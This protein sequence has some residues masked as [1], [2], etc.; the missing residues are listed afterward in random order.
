VCLFSPFEATAASPF[1]T[2]DGQRFIDAEGRHL[3]LHG[4]N[5]VS[6]NRRANYQP[7]VTAE[8][9][10]MLRSWGWNC[11]RL[12]VIWDGLEPEMGAFDEAYL[13]KL[14]GWVALA[15][16]YGF[17]VILD[18]HQ[19]LFSYKYADGA[20]EWATLDD[21]MPH[22]R[23]NIW[24]DAYLISPAVQQAFDNFWENKPCADGM[25][26]QDHF[27]A[28]WK[29]LAQRYKDEE[30]IVAY[31]LFNEPNIGSD[32]TALILEVL[33]AYALNVDKLPA[34]EEPITL[35]D[36]LDADNGKELRS[37]LTRQVG[38]MDFYQALL[39]AATPRCTLFESTHMT[40]MFQRVRD[41]IRTVDRNH[42]I[43]LETN[44]SANLGVPTGVQPL[45]DEKGQ[46]DP[47]QAFA[48]HAYDIVV[49]THELELTNTDRLD[50]IFRRHAKSGERL[51]MP[52]VVGEWGAFGAGT[53]G[54]LPSTRHTVNLM[55]KYLMSNTYWDYSHRLEYS[56]CMEI[57]Q[58][59]IARNTNG[60]LLSCATDFEASAFQCR[61]EEDPAVTAPTSIYLPQR[62]AAL[63][64]TISVEPAR[65]DFTIS[66]PYENS[67]A[68]LVEIPPLGTKE[69]RSFY[70]GEK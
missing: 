64:D 63:I 54:I 69:L 14:D 65:S 5:I 61:W 41:A 27:A 33:N 29:K 70:I 15:K 10:K 7:R 35:Q 59:P 11:I 2:V 17:Y 53:P 51:N 6:K 13:E 38:N 31:D 47:L 24:S 68:V 45:Q 48:P 44:I 39:D 1:V 16:E 20:P 26:V 43:L 37:T 4:V 12:G 18:M 42:I 49:D 36:V 25:G 67:G 8:D 62:M 32:N 66:T 3:L 58:R 40:A 55:E 21:G 46:R 28:A 60:T 22:L 56:P 57:F 19:D 34:G 50:L 9:F 30:A 52:I 23:G